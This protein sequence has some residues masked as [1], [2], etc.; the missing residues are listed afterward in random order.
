MLQRDR[1]GQE[2]L[3]TLVRPRTYDLCS[4]PS[5]FRYESLVHTRVK[6]ESLSGYTTSQNL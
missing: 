4:L 1:L 3:V 6:A 5:T 2:L